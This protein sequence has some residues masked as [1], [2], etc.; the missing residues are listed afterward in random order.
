MD[1]GSLIVETFQDDARGYVDEDVQFSPGD[2][3]DLFHSVLPG[4]VSYD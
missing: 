4:D 3:R 2:I 1:D